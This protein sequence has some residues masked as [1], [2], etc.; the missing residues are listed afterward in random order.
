MFL[1][2]NSET[3]IGGF[4]FWELQIENSWG[5]CRYLWRKVDFSKLIWGREIDYLPFK[6]WA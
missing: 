4:G 6:Y 1:E 3:V 5:V 2:S